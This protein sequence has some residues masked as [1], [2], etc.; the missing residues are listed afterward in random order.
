M[1]PN[2]I[3]IGAERCG[4]TSLHRYLASHRQIFMS[5]QKELNFFVAEGNW[6]RGASWY[7]G[8]FPVDAP[9][10]GESSPSYTSHPQ[11][12]GVPARMSSLVPSA[13][14]VYLVRDPVERAISAVHLA[15]A[16]GLER[17]T[18]DAALRMASNPYITRSRYAT[19]LE[20]YLE[21]FPVD[22]IAVIDSHDLRVRRAE[23]L[24]AIF[25]F[26]G[27]DE[28]GWS[29]E[30]DEEFGTLKRRRRN[31]AGQ[32]LFG[33]GLKT[34]GDPRT[35]SIMRHAPSWAAAPLTAPMTPTVVNAAVRDELVSTFT[36][37]AARLRAL[38]GMRFESWSV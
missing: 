13:K 2:L 16:I 22:A 18:P 20:Q 7:A 31:I 26:L 9:V 15:R 27:I 23:T 25:R 34:L 3:V 12:V 37:E 29:A 21:H 10:R 36:D 1:L 4:T 17:A 14:L 35:R 5:A 30:M 19:Q 38:T 8:C 33:V 32:M 6:R 11:F 24:R 28:E